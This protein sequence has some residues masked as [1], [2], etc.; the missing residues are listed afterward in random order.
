MF[1]SFQKPKK[2]NITPP[3]RRKNTETAS[4]PE[5]GLKAVFPCF[6]KFLVESD[7]SLP[8]YVSYRRR[9]RFG[10][11]NQRLTYLWHFIAKK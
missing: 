7:L 9:Q 3:K 1:I 11:C 4:F 6:K 8:C 2:K 5:N 10:I